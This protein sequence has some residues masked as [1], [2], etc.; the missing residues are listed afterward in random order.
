[1]GDFWKVVQ[2]KRNWRL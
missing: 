1:M 2:M